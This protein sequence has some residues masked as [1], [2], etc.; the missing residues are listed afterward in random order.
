MIEKYVIVPWD[1]AQEF[2][3]LDEWRSCFMCISNDVEF[4]SVPFYAIPVDLY[5]KFN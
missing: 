3:K 1:K 5:Y 2:M 4:H